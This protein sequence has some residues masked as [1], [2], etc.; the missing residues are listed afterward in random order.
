M[1]T[2]DELINLSD[3]SLPA[4]FMPTE[5]KKAAIYNPRAHQYFH[6]TGTL[7]LLTEYCKPILI[8]GDFI[9]R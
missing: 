2:N 6:P 9:S 5:N 1:Q 8:H 4:L 7:N 3:V